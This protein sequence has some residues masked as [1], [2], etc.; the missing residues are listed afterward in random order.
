VIGIW[1]A[2]ILNV[3]INVGV[4]GISRFYGPTGHCRLILRVF[5]SPKLTRCKGCWISGEFSV[6]EIVADFLW[7]WISAFFSV[8]AYVPVFLVL[9]GFVETEGWRVRWTNER[10]SPH[11]ASLFSS[12]R[13]AYK[14][15]A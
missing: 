9:G 8:L 12:R 11:L 4:N 3:A 14:M 2:I 10:Q 5:A 15:L 13:V 1:I 6:Q 7:M